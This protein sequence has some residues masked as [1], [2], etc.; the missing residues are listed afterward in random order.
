MGTLIKVGSILFL[1]MT[2]A[3]REIEKSYQDVINRGIIERIFDRPALLIFLFYLFLIYIMQL[4]VNIQLALVIPNTL[5][6]SVVLPAIILEHRWISKV[7]KGEKN[8]RLFFD[9]IKA[10]RSGFIFSG[11]L[12]SL[13]FLTIAYI[14][15]I[16]LVNPLRSKVL[17]GNYYI[18]YSVNLSHIIAIILSS[19]IGGGI[20]AATFF[21]VRGEEHDTGRR[22]TFLSTPAQITTF[23]SY[24]LIGLYS[25]LWLL[26]MGQ[27]IISPLIGSQRQNIETITSGTFSFVLMIVV[28]LYLTIAYAAKEIPK[29]I[30]GAHYRVP[31]RSIILKWIRDISI[32]T[33]IASTFMQ[34]RLVQVNSVYTD[35]MMS[36][37]LITY[38]MFPILYLLLIRKQPMSG[39]TCRSCNLIKHDETCVACDGK[40][41]LSV[42][43]KFKRK[44]QIRHPSCPSCGTKWVNLT[45]TCAN[46]SCNFKIE[47]SCEFCGNKINPLWKKCSH[48]DK[49]RVSIVNKA[50]QAPG[51][52]GFARSIAYIRIIMAILVPIFIMQVSLIIRTIIELAG[53]NFDVSFAYLVYSLTIGTTR[54]LLIFFAFI[55]TVGILFATMREKKRPLGLIANRHALISVIILMQ[56][57]FFVFVFNSFS[58]LENQGSIYLFSKI[59]VVLLSL[60]FLYGSI[61]GNYKTL[62][63]FRPIT[64]F[65]PKL[66]LDRRIE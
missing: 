16:F 28:T 7:K 20:I 33:I 11:F 62:L 30:N 61:R 52:E 63:T 48:C 51:S 43:F 26:W 41:H 35:S 36:I 65:D 17:F 23:S 14:F 2:V 56:S 34:N 54:L 44:K 66:S 59:L 29:I 4:I 37:D 32:Y 24:S 21:R 53:D 13:L 27:L 15:G 18:L 1:D 31:D 42:P 39:D 38:S 46:E 19:I 25:T 50:L 49:E 40:D 45:R 9:I 58:N 57:I 64:P 6:L 10:N 47:L 60:F 22:Y 5:L 3:V 8:S 12:S 55:G